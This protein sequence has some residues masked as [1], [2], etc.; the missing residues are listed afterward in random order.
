MSHCIYCGNAGHAGKSN[1]FC[2]GFFTQ[3]KRKHVFFTSCRE[4][5]I[6]KKESKLQQRKELHMSKYCRTLLFHFLKIGADCFPKEAEW[7]IL[8]YK[9]D[10]PFDSKMA[11]LI[12]FVY[13]LVPTRYLVFH[14]VWLYVRPCL[15]PFYLHV[16]LYSHFLIKCFVVFHFQVI[17]KGC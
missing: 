13:V 4:S 2:K 1:W 14:K 5:S 7:L 8:L 9:W 17:L 3:K 10:T 12:H 15:F 16:L 6:G 11:S